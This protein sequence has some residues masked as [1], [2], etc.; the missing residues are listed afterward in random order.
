MDT[1]TT[2]KFGTKR[3][4]VA[5]AITAVL[6]TL[7]VI[8]SKH[9]PALPKLGQDDVPMPFVFENSLAGSISEIG[10]KGD[11]KVRVVDFSD[12]VTVES[13]QG[14]QQVDRI[15]FVLTP[16]DMTVSEGATLEDAITPGRKIFGYKY[17][18]QDGALEKQ[19]R[20]E[21]A[22]GTHQHTFADLF[23]GEFFVSS[24]Q[25]SFDGYVNAFEQDHAVVFKPMSQVTLERSAR[26]IV[27][28]NDALTSFT[29]R[30]LQF[31]G[32]GA[33]KSDSR[34]QCDDANENDADGCTA[35]CILS[36]NPLTV[37][38][39]N[40]DE[41]GS[42]IPTGFSIPVGQFT[43]SMAAS[44]NPSLASQRASLRT[45]LFSVHASNVEIAGPFMLYNKLDSMQQ[46]PCSVVDTNDQSR[47]EAS[48]SGNFFVRC[49]IDQ[50]SMVN[51]T[52]PRG[53]QST[54]VLSMNVTN[55]TVSVTAPSS[56]QVILERM[57]DPA[58]QNAAEVGV[59]KSHLQW[60]VVSVDGTSK[61]SMYV[62]G[63]NDA[64]Q[65]T[66]YGDVIVQCGNGQTDASI[67]EQC[68][69]GNALAGDGCSPSCRNEVCGN[70][71]F[72]PGEQC[73]DGNQND[74]DTCSNTCELIAAPF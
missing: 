40:P 27:V 44:T 60:D 63:G 22:A 34:E 46:A 71:I 18:T 61:S 21:L 14:T 59:T 72:D 65:S 55:P 13:L 36:P 30:N 28:A 45:L 11:A 7:I 69:D 8:L 3:A 51:T 56:L 12:G 66:F 5:L 25:R 38:N 67:G 47:S 52:I 35:Q 49:T 20:A 31:C 48:F 16:D 1:S 68:D 4:M 29:A 37:E 58:L 42:S 62:V 50:M 32:D 24:E 26:Y 9:R 74:N 39:A 41:H 53:S 23:P 64:V 43:F 57:T 73:D 70:G 2:H 6:C 17:M 10:V 15:D 19:R 33:L 54:F